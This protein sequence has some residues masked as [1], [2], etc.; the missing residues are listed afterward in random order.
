MVGL[1]VRRTYH[2]QAHFASLEKKLI[3]VA[4]TQTGI[5][6]WTEDAA[7]PYQTVP[8]PGQHWQ[9]SGMPQR[10][11]HEYVR[12]G[13]AKQLTLFHP[14]SGQ[15]RVK[16]VRS[17][18]NAVLHPWLQTELLAI[19]AG[20]PPAPVVPDEEQRRAWE[21][22]RAGLPVRI[23]WREAAARGWNRAPT[24]FVWGGRRRA[25]RERARQRRHALGGSGACTRRPLPRHRSASTIGDKQPK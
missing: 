4:Y 5:P 22:W 1:H 6:V 8:Y 13:T 17:C 24:P 2:P 3:E 9:P 12:E 21:R 7:G 19:L 20:L 25:R 15:V 11:P 23:T 10:H 18:T 16:G 14:A